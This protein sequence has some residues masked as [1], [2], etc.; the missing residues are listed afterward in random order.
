M[1]QLY[2]DEAERAAR[3]SE[4]QEQLDSELSIIIQVRFPGYSPI[5]RDF[6]SWAKTRDYPIGPGH[7]SSTGSL[8][9]HS[10]KITNLGPLRY[11]LSFE[12]F[13]SP[14]HVPMPDFDTD[15]C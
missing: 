1:V 13:L 2:P 6:I 3:M 5:V 11:T 14:G 7:G 9:T 10:L 4:Y 8:M 15:S 12:R